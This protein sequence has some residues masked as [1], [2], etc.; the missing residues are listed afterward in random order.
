MTRR[1][2][3]GKDQAKVLDQMLEHKSTLEEIDVARKSWVDDQDNNDKRFQYATI[4]C[5][6]PHEN[7]RRESVIHFEYLMLNERNY[8]F[9]GLYNLSLVYYTLKDWESARAYCETLYR[10]QPDNPQVRSLHAAIAYKFD[11]DQQ[12]KDDQ[13]NNLTIAAGVGMGIAAVGLGLLFGLKKR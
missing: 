10:E 5:K 6:S 12:R 9:D 11:K 13:A 1:Q 8:I 2:I 4:L 7:D 3:P